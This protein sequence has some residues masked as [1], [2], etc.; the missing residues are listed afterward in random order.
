MGGRVMDEEKGTGSLVL[1]GK[2][3]KN[4]YTTFFSLSYFFLR[5]GKERLLQRASLPLCQSQYKSDFLR[6]FPSFNI[7]LCQATAFVVVVV[8]VIVVVAV[9]SSPT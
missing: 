3:K 7:I 1:K 8:V 6:D 2:L 5:L 9:V 4:P